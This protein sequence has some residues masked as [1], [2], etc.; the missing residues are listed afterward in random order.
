MDKVRKSNISVCYTPSSEP[1]S[2]YKYTQS[3]QI[4]SAL[5]KLLILIF[6]ISFTTILISIARVPTFPIHVIERRNKLTA[7]T[8]P[9]IGEAGWASERDKLFS[10]QHWCYLTLLALRWT[11]P[12]RPDY[13]N[14]YKDSFHI[15]G[16]LWVASK[17]HLDSHLW[18]Y[19]Q[20]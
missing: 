12:S 2:I 9:L 19:K 18:Q 20:E 6:S 5:P 11:S 10:S 14:K 13:R 8:T 1:Y 16:L 3:W 17:G 15:M 7:N 4:F